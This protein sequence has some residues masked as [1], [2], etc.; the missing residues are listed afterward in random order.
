MPDSKPPDPG[1]LHIRNQRY[2]PYW[3]IL[4]AMLISAMGL[5]TIGIFFAGPFDRLAIGFILAAYLGLG[6]VIGFAFV[7]RSVARR[8]FGNRPRGKA[9]SGFDWLLR[10][11]GPVR[12]LTLGDEIVIE[13]GALD[14]RFRAGAGS[15]IRFAPDPAE[16]YAEAEKAILMCQAVVEL[17]PVKQFR[18]IVSETD[19]QRL[20][21]W[22]VAKG[23]A[24]CD[25]DG[26]SPRAVETASEI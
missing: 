17:D 16:D 5:A 11:L 10:R 15:R 7:L 1:E 22:A 26:Y 9:R 3:E 12:T 6:A 8:Q 24:V 20:R 18:L 13:T 23:I 4:Q 25:S 2:R 19:A 14:F 21:H